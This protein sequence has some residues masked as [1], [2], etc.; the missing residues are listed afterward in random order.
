MFAKALF[1]EVEA[2]SRRKTPLMQQT[3]KKAPCERAQ[4]NFTQGVERWKE[5]L[6]I[7]SGVNPKAR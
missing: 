1:R 4:E 2:P 5:P 7:T 3:S 6:G